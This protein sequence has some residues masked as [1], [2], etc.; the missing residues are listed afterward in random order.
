MGK[1]L[2]KKSHGFFFMKKFQEIYSMFSLN[3]ST[4]DLDA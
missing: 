1:K 3:M 4:T 2:Q